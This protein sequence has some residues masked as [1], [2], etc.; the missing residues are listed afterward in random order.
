MKE[1]DVFVVNAGH[2]KVA[3]GS[4]LFSLLKSVVGSGHKPCGYD[5]L[6]AKLN[7][8]VRELSYLLD[9]DSTVRFIDLN[10]EDGIRMYRRSMHFVFIKS[11]LELYPR[12]KPVIKHSISSGIYFELL[13]DNE[14]TQDEIG[15][16]RQ[17]MNEIIS[18]KIPF[19]KTDVSLEYARKIYTDTG[20]E[21]KFHL[22]E[23]RA[24]DHVTL[25]DLGG[26]KDYFY[27]YMVP[28]TGY[29][30]SFR[31]IKYKHGAIIVF[32]DRNDPGRLPY[33]RPQ[34]KLFTIFREHEIDGHLLGC[35]S[36][37]D[38]N[39]IVKKGKIDELID[40]SEYLHSMK[41]KDIESEITEKKRSVVFIAG[42]SSSGKTSAALRIAKALN[43]MS[44]G[45][46][47]ISM[48]DYFLDQEETPKDE[49]GEKDFEAMG[50]M[51]IRLFKSNIR[52]L[53]MGAEIQKPTFDFSTGKRNKIYQL[54]RKGKNDIIIVEG[55]HGLDPSVYS[56]YGRK[57][58]YRIYVSSLTSMNI[59]DHNRIPTTESRL[60]RRI[61]RDII[62]RGTSPEDTLKRWASV[63]N[64]EER[65]IFPFQDNADAIFNSSLYYELAILK[66]YADKIIKEVSSDV[67]EYSEARS[68]SVFLSYICPAGSRSIPDD[69][70]I[71]EFIGESMLFTQRNV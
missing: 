40:K 41:I 38:L 21:D 31:L 65:Y 10:D 30:K 46:L 15:K 19:V 58:L 54:M 68:M 47:T 42:P 22:I 71:K 3:G 25:Y 43:E 64:G 17:R 45:T 36:I 57:N 52:D 50:A 7:N 49:Y 23:Q 56:E 59:D 33:F 53:I 35:K 24:S 69:S 12:K 55:L 1:I 39:N 48:D 9:K 34:P 61:V 5:V 27:G 51:D 28:N 11:V 44:V 60:L 70:I 32:P 18:D 20:R 26:T 66:P 6:G 62:S 63:R 2:F 16:I 8:E 14:T 4:S 13:D 37:G 67:P 29:L